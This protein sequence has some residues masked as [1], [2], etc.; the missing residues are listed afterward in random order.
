MQRRADLGAQLSV[1]E[2]L[3]DNLARLIDPLAGIGGAQ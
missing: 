3:I 1:D 2:R